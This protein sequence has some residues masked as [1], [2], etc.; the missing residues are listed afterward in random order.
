MPVKRRCEQCRR[1]GTRG[2]STHHATW[3]DPDGTWVVDINPQ[4]TCTN[5]TA[6]RKRWP[7]RPTDES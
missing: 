2:F 4:I 3:Q 5:K 7:K 6:C 1:V